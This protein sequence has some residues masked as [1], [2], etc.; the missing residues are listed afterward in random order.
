LT[1]R[2][3]VGDWFKGMLQYTLSRTID[4]TGGQF[5]LPA[6]NFDLRAE[7][8]R[9][10]FDQR[11]RFKFAGRLKMPYA[12]RLGANLSLASG[13][14]FDITTGSDDNLDTVANDRPPGVT[15]NTGQGAGLAVLDLRLTK[16]FRIP[17]P[18]QSGTHSS[19]DPGDLDISVDGFNAL[20]RTNFSKFIGAQSSPFFGQ[21]ISS[22]PARKVQLSLKYSF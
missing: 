20:N 17:N 9:A 6:N 2:G 15:R 14:P 18:F 4:D 5:A 19:G 12:F 10:D 3:R 7:M 13:A 22:L 1:F 21:A 16:R 8:G 11:H